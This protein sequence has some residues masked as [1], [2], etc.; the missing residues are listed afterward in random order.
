LV[1]G[2][3]ASEKQWAAQVVA[4]ARRLGWAVFYVHDSRL[5]PRGWPDLVL[6]RPPRFAVAELKA[7]GGRIRPE[8]ALWLAALRACPGVEVYIWRPSDYAKVEEVLK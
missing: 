7:E 1:L 2:E 5:S 6:C 8:Q 3:V 4:M